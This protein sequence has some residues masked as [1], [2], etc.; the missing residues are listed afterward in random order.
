VGLERANAGFYCNKQVDA[1]LAT[2]K[3]AADDATYLKALAD[4]QKI[5]SVDDPA[6]IYYLQPK[7]TTVL[8]HDIEGFVFNPIYQGTYDFYRLRRTG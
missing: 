2:A 1:D 4:A 6:S 8:R 3:D 7:W 5:L